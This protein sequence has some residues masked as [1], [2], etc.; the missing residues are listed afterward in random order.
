MSIGCEE[1]FGRSTLTLPWLGVRVSAGRVWVHNVM[2]QSWVALAGGHKVQLRG[3]RTGTACYGMR[4]RDTA[5]YQ[6]IEVP[7]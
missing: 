3:F 4:S 2:E 1:R 7:H 5:T 6:L